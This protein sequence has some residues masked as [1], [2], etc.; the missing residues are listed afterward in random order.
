[1]GKLQNETPVTLQN[2]QD[3]A[4][5]ALEAENI[6]H[7]VMTALPTDPATDIHADS[8]LGELMGTTDMATYSRT[9]DSMETQSNKLG[10]FS[11]DGGAAQDDSAKASLDLAH[12][13]LDSIIT[14]VGK[15]PKSDGTESFN[16]TALAAIEAEATD[17]I[18]AD[19]LDHLL[20]L[21]GA[22]QKY[23]ENCA[24]DSIVAKMLAKGDPAAVTTYDCTTDSQEAV[25]DKLGGFSGDG[26]AAQD[27]SVKAS[28]DL[29]H[30]DLDAIITDLDNG[31]DG[32]GALKAILDTSGVLA[33]A[34]SAAYAKL[35]GV[36]QSAVT[37]E[38]LAQAAGSYDLF[39]GTTQDVL[40]KSLVIRLPNVD[41]SDDASLTSIS[42]QTDDVTPAVIISA[43]AGA[44]AN[45]TAEA[46]LAYTGA[47]VIKTGTKIQLTIAGGAADAATVCDVVTECT[48]VANGGYLA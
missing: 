37:T 24:E 48:A 4:E 12:T 42:I 18:E 10:G 13:D 27:D 33:N 3:E 43:A 7:I 28:M 9:T 36:N 11:G 31:T 20:T 26:G 30:T 23:P 8:A 17:A 45:L 25:S 40:L 21:D 41:C 6:D 14:E 22:T 29:A 19:D 38:D 15:V 46:Q 34:R 16:A 1:M 47:I 35:A 5:D 32:L 2:I 39:T 44:V